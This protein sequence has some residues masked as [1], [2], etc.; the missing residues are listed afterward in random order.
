MQFSGALLFAF[1]AALGNALFALGQKKATQ[2]ENPL[3]F[4]AVSATFCIMLTLT[5]VSLIG[6]SN[7]GSVIRQNGLWAAVSGLGLFL[8]YLGFNLLYT[9]YGASQY[10]LYAVLSILTTSL[11]VGLVCFKEHF[12]GYHWAA[13]AGALI[14][15]ILFSMGQNRA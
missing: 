11:F 15:V 1:V 7:Y 6:R 8:T 14:T 12:N 3:A 9:R 4:V 10:I 2:V 13:F 5:T